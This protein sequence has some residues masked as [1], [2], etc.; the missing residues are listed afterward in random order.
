MKARRKVVPG[1]GPKRTPTV[2]TI[3]PAIRSPQGSG[4]RFTAGLSRAADPSPAAST[5][6]IGGRPVELAVE[7]IADISRKKKW[8]RSNLLSRPHAS[9]RS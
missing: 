1:I 5:D 4:G 7:N 8:Q 3:R 9:W 6:A 2:R